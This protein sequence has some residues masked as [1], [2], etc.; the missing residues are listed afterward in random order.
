M[1]AWILVL[2]FVA[3]A[4]LHGYWVVVGTGDL[5]AFVP[6]PEAGAKPLFQPGRF[7]TAVVALLLLAAAW[8]CASEAR[9]L[10]LPRLPLAGLGVRVLAGLFFLRAVGD[11]KYVG[12]FKK[13][14]ETRFGRMD[15]RVFSPL[16]LTIA[17]LCG[18]LAFGGS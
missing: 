9:L 14:R 6:E 13:V 3:L 7:V 8:V 4:A 12:F 5:S 10:G 2:I 18:V 11:F 1:V 17:L 15:T 16:C